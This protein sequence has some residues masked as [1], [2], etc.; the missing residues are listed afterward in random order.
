MVEI[1]SKILLPVDKKITE[2]IIPKNITSLSDIC[3]ESCQNLLTIKIPNTICH[4][5]NYCFKNCQNLLSIEIPDSVTYI[6]SK[7]F[8][9]CY[10]LTNVK[11]SNNIKCIEEY[12][13]SNCKQLKELIIPDS[14]EIL[15]RKFL[16]LCD[17]D[18]I[19]IGNG[20]KTINSNA[21]NGCTIKEVYT[22]NRI[23]LNNSHLLTFCGDLDD[24]RGIYMDTRILPLEENS[25]YTHK[26]VSE[27]RIRKIILELL[28][29]SDIKL[30]IEKEI[31]LE[32]RKTSDEIMKRIDELSP[33]V[34]PMVDSLFQ[35][36]K[37]NEEE[38]LKLIRL[39]EMLKEFK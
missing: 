24:E 16:C 10:K 38:Y 5:G 35:Q 29:K 8:E 19:I 14:V 25:I 23:I 9:N 28:N 18:K 7:A 33:M 37:K 22:N 21:F 36:L 30:V 32:H 34:L 3:F 6:G 26:E 17:M 15:K 39:Y 4:I 2:C 12:T 31:K 13:F 11:L 27:D 20:V 1:N